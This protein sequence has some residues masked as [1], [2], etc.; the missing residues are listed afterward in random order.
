MVRRS[1][2][3]AECRP[4]PTD[5]DA[6]SGRGLLL[7]A[8]LA[9]AWGVTDRCSG[10]GKTVWAVLNTASSDRPGRIRPQAPALPRHPTG[11]PLSP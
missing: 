8:A 1:D 6:V 9:D 5:P 7:V 2:T 11:L 3:R 10:P 4:A